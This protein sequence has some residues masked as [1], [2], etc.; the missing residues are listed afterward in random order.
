MKFCGRCM[1]GPY[2]TIECQREPMFVRC[3]DTVGGIGVS[4]GAEITNQ[5]DFADT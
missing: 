4:G 1:S 3:S 5:I 2:F